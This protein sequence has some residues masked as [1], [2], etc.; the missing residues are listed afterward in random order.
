MGDNKKVSKTNKQKKQKSITEVLFTFYAFILFSLGFL[1]VFFTKE[2]DVISFN[3][4]KGK[5]AY[6]F[7]KFIGSFELLSSFLIFS[8]RKLKGR[9]IYYSAVG[10]IIAGFIN[11]YL[12]SLLSEYII[13]PSVY[14]IFQTIVQFSFFVV[15]FDQ[16]KGK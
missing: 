6:I 9:V 5:I 3:G 16:A 14:F 7:L 10:L 2:F 12:L 1:I 13:L 4:E 8:L 11:L 15:I